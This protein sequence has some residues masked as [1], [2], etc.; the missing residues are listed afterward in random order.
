MAKSRFRQADVKRALTGAKAAGFEVGRF[1]IDAE[2][3]I[4][5]IAK[6]AR[7]ASAGD[8]LGEYLAKDARTTQRH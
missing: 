3:N 7:D 2:G 1:T 8:P 4:T 5:I 6:N